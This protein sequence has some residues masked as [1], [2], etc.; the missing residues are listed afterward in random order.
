MTEVLFEEVSPLGNVQAVVEADEGA[1]YFYLFGAPESDFGMRSVWVR[2]LAAAPATLDVASMKAGL[3]PLNPAVHC[4]DPRAGRPPER[5]ELRV[6]WLPEGNGAALYDA[7]GLLAVIPPWSGEK[8][9]DGYAR[10]AV[11]EGPVAWALP[12]T[13]ALQRR[14]EKAAEFWASW[15][16]DPWPAFQERYCSAFDKALGPH[17]NYYAIDGGKWPPRALLR[18]PH[19]SGIALV[20][21]GVCLLP[22]P[23]VE[24]H[25]ED[26]G[27]FRRI[28][29][30]VLLPS[31]FGDAD[32]NRFGGYL[33]GQAGLPWHKF[34]WLGPGHTIPCDSWR[35]TKY[36]SAL[37]VREHRHLPA[38]QL[39]SMMGDPVSVL[40]FVPITDTE[41]QL[42]IESGSSAL[43]ARL[44]A[45]RWLEG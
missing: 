27:D 26:P 19:R 20:T 1:C 40:W 25:M 28:E 14:F 7:R 42:A 9:F 39:P 45:S 10:E 2:N 43:L 15:D 23:N 32:V 13:D 34:T 35:S 30:G 31:D 22:Q 17:S 33:S 36:T 16:D 29:L 6:C 4:R 3:P 8:G 41:R 37:L 18:L 12:T 5:G 21:I 44:P 38:M 11:G 24:R